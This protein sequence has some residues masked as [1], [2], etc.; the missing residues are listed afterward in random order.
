MTAKSLAMEEIFDTQHLRAGDRHVWDRLYTSTCRRTYH[1]LSHLTNAQQQ[2][3]EELNQEVWLS[4]IQAIR[5]FDATQGTAVDWVLGIARHKGLDFLRKHYKNRVTCVGGSGDLPMPSVIP[6]DQLLIAERERLLRAA[7]ESLPE[8]WQ[9]VLK[10]K[11][12][13]SL[14]ICEIANLL[15]ST[16]KAVESTLSRARA[17]LRELLNQ[18]E[19]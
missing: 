15:E 4:A 10:Q 9:F 2:V 11:Y 3:L 17:R 12:H 14:S 7:I 8:K 18:V 13:L 16:P 5:N 19:M 1:I 6:E